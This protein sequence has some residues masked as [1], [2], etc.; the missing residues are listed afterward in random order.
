VLS[1]LGL[2]RLQLF[3]ALVAYAWRE[4]KRTLAT[5]LSIGPPAYRGSANRPESEA[6]FPRRALLGSWMNTASSRS[7]KGYYGGPA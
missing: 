7:A 6:Q 1:A 4:A 3:Y 2:R 5:V